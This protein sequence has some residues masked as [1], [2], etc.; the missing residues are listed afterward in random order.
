MRK[1]EYKNRMLP[2]P[3]AVK[4]GVRAARRGRIEFKGLRTMAAARSLT[5][6]CSSS[7]DLLS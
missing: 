1:S 6:A 4:Q 7:P 2:S 3:T 5:A